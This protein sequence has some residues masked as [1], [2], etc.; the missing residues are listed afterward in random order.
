LTNKVVD[1]S[2]S[3]SQV[4]PETRSENASYMSGRGVSKVFNRSIHALKQVDFDI[5][6]GE[7]V[8]LLGHNGSGK[9]TLLRCM[10]GLETVSAGSIQFN[11]VDLT[12]LNK[13]ALRKV[14]RRIGVVFQRFNLVGNLSAFQ[15]V[16]FGAMGEF[17]FL[18]TLH[19]IAK[20][21]LRE[22]AMEALERVGLAGKASQRADSLSGGQ[23]QRVAIAR[24]LMQ[25]PEVLLADEPIASLDPK[26][27]RGVME[28]LWEVGRERHFTV[29]CTLHQLDIA[30]DY[31]ERLIGLKQGEKVLDG[32]AKGLTCEDLAWLYEDVIDDEHDG[33]AHSERYQ[34][35]TYTADAGERKSAVPMRG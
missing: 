10:N 16:L 15:N 14:R 34:M 11:G 5:Q 13:A 9:S 24:T 18:R 20:S 31:G 4:K 22:K 28:L 30:L 19:P 27:A 33:D 6:R 2:L 8:V 3:L 25:D 32:P 35:N 17:G 1:S 23:Q 29:I 21:E 12:Q 26:A 7:G